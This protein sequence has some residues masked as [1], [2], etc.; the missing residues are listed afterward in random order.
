MCRPARAVPTTSA[1]WSTCRCSCRCPIAAGETWRS[2]SPAPWG[3]APR[4]WP[5]GT[6]A[7]DRAGGECSPGVRPGLGGS[8]LAG[9]PAHHPAHRGSPP[10]HQHMASTPHPT[11]YPRPLDVSGQGYNNWIFM[12]THFW[13]EDPQGLWT[14][15]LENKGYYF[16]TGESYRQAGASGSGASRAPAAE[17]LLAVSLG[18]WAG[19]SGAECAQSVVLSPGATGVGDSSLGSGGLGRGAQ[20]GRTRWP[21]ASSPPPRAHRNPCPGTLYRYTLL[22]YGTAEDMT[23]RPSGPQVTSSACVQRDTEGLCQGECLAGPGL[24]AGRRQQRA[25]CVCSLGRHGSRATGL[26]LMPPYMCPPYRMPQPR[27]HPGPPLPGLLPSKVLQPHPAGSDPRA[28]ALGDTHP[29]HLLQLPRLLLYLPRGVPAQLHHLPPIVHAG[30]AS[31]LLLRTCPSQQ[32]PPAHRSGPAQLPPWPSPGCGDGLA[33]HG[34]GE[35]LPLQRPVWRLPAAMGGPP[36]C[37]ASP[38]RHP[39]A[40]CWR[41]PRAI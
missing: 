18:D 20:K 39:R 22:L 33:G 8:A 37:R 29:A 28:W 27:L 21:T 11:I 16:N 30:Q 5:S 6:G 14:L 26:G 17:G 31:G 24:P 40:G 4:S 1:H 25:V 38:H 23:A 34:L 2:R 19:A 13:D 32:H 9:C 10:S 7:E 36:P 15:G 41:E 12:S 35:P 3:P